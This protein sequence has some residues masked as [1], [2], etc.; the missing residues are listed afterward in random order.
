MLLRAHRQSA[1]EPASSSQ[2]SDI[3]FFS[4]L[5]V[6]LR[7]LLIVPTALEL[8]AVYSLCVSR[9]IYM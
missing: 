9:H 7:Q 6:Y 1:L 2:K 8:C 3:N 5:C 4:V